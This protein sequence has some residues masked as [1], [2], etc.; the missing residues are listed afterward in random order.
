MSSRSG[1]AA[2]SLL[3]TPARVAIAGDWHA[4]TT[5]T[6]GAGYPTIVDGRDKNGD[7]IDNNMVVLNWRIRDRIG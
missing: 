3:A 4:D 2:T 7:P 5:Y 6:V 1:P